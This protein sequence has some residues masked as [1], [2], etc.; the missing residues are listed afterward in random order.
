MR[1][2]SRM[3]PVLMLAAA[4]AALAATS[5][6]ADAIM[7]WNAHSD[8]IAAEKAIRPVQ[9]SRNK[10]ML[11]VAMFEAVNAIERRYA[12]YKLNLSADRTASKEAAAASAAHDV[13][14]AVLPGP[15]G[16]ARRGIGDGAGR[17]PRGR[18]EN[19]R[20]RCRQESRGRR[21]SPCAPVTASRRRRRYRPHT[22][23]GVYVPTVVPVFST[24]GAVTP[25]VMTSGSQFRPAPPPALNSE[26]WT[27][28]LNEIRE[29]GASQQHAA[30]G[31][32]D[33]DRPVL[34]RRRS[35]HLQSDRAPGRG[36]EGDGP[37]R[38]R[39]P[40]RA[41]RHGRKRRAHRG[42]RCQVHLQ[43]LATGHGDPQCRSDRQRGDAAR[44]I[45]A[46]ARRHADAPRVPVR[47][48]HHLG[49][50]RRRCS[51]RWPATRSGS[52]R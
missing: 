25:W 48:L 12:P 42:V 7:D 9:H 30:H 20:H 33:D 24:A 11:Q 21:S 18:A 1:S 28:D 37:G 32:A 45:V 41:R 6:R 22:S 52:L 39:A 27:R 26:T 34:V 3:L 5:A 15:E 13:L 43:S 36:R 10:A 4:L 49:C 23:P 46:A 8:A 44:G 17:N 31:R 29:L 40:L 14:I 47:A 51:R 19:E 35:A 16:Q 50:G 2:R 38:L